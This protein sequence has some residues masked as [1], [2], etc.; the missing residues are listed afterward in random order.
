MDDN[1]NSTSSRNISSDPISS[2]DSSSLISKNPIPDNP[3]S[4]S[5][6]TDNQMSNNSSNPSIKTILRLF[7]YLDDRTKAKDLKIDDDSICYISVR[8]HAEKISIIVSNYIT[9]LGLDPKEA[10]VTDATACVGGN[11][12][13]FAK[14]FKKVNA[15]EI[16]PTRV[17][18]LK[19]N[20][21][22]YKIQNV[23][24]F[25]G[26]CLHFLGKIDHQ[27]VVF[28]D[29]PWGG[30][31]YKNYSSLRL[32]LSGVSLEEICN[33]LLDKNSVKCAPELV[34][35]KLPINYDVNYF[36][37]SLK[38]RFIYFIDLRKMYIFVVANKEIK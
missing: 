33:S 15:I 28:I 25:E 19:N 7:P 6:D 26:D 27:H 1:Q 16:D 34:V 3:I 31:S 32:S 13:S 4:K 2:T 20:I 22:V 35:I 37:K 21:D 30:P 29:P 14:N 12:L 10:I 18:Y 17:A 5:A 11:T 36:Y 9:K 24:V 38:N 23:E 8:E